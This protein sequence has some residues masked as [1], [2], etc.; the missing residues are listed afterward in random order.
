MPQM[1]AKPRQIAKRAK[2]LAMSILD[3]YS[4]RKRQRANS[5]K[6]DVYRYDE[7]AAPLR[8]QIID[9]WR[10]ATGPVTTDYGL[11]TGLHRNDHSWDL[12]Q[13]IYEALRHEKG[14]LRLAPGDD[15]FARCAY[16]FL[17]PQ[18]GIDDLLDVLELVFRCIANRGDLQYWVRQE[19]EISMTATEAIHELNFRLREAGV[20]YQFESGGI[21]RVSS[22]YTHAEVVRPALTL[23]PDPRFKGPHEEF[24]HAHDRYRAARSAD[25]N[26]LE[27]SIAWALK[28]YES[29]MKVIYGLMGWPHSPNATA[30]PLVQVLVDN[31]LVPMY[32][33]SSLE[34]L[35]T[36]S[37]RASRHGQGAQVRNTPDYFAAYALH[38]AAANIVMLIEAFK[39][40]TGT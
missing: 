16:F 33:K 10:W 23:L 5:G 40:G 15:P 39:A 38:Q 14:V 31:G 11:G 17:S 21:I 7:I 36:L 1:P 12:W 20:G 4:R 32:L 25:V 9:L 24:L 34:S 30:A 19:R 35:A 2:I 13:E 28:A 29:T 18:T 8:I 27:D 6:A 37:N 26:T 3:S 22:Q